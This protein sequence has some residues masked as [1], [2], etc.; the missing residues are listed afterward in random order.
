MKVPFA[1]LRAMHE[2]VRTEIEAAWRGLVDRSAFVGGPAVAEF[3]HAF[4]EYCEVPHAVGVGSGTDALRIAL[5]AVGI[6]AGDLVLTVPQTFIATV[7]AIT[8]AGASPVFIDIE[9]DS[10]TMDPALV[11]AYLE[12]RCRSQD[13]ILVERQSGRRVAGLVPVDL[14]G[15]PADWDRLVDLARKFEL[16]VVEDACQAHGARYRGSR[17]GSFGHAAAFSFYPGKNLGAMGEAGAITTADAA[18]AER[19]RVLRDHGQQER[20]IHV[21]GDGSN[22]R[23]DALQ[24]AVLSAKLHRLEG[25]NEARRRVAGWYASRLGGLGMTLPPEMSWAT[26][27]YHLYVVLLGERDRVRSALESAGVQTGLHYPV[28]LHLQQAYRSLG[29]GPGDFPVSEHVASRALSLP[30]FPHLTERHVD[31]VAAVLRTALG[32]EVAAR[33]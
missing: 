1:D 20:Y 6:R 14:Y 26:H 8:Q 16:K 23:L 5:Q 11:G 25:W 13:G 9:S 12:R 32:S 2:E 7:E 21:T 22:A 31:H 10:Y 4:A 30:M 27:V 29:H 15:H 17:C 19:C 33:Q 3:E 24:A 28:P 18:V